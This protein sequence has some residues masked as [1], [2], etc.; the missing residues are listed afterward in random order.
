MTDGRAASSGG[1]GFGLSRVGS[2]TLT[3]GAL[4]QADVSSCGT[5]T[6]ADDDGGNGGDGW[7]PD[8]VTISCSLD[9]SQTTEGEGVRGQFTVQ[10]NN[11]ISVNVSVEVTANDET[12]TEESFIVPA[13]DS[14]SFEAIIGADLSPDTYTISADLAAIFRVTDNQ[15]GLSRV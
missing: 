11:S 13:N 14:L 9:S 4:P 1:S 5:I 15:F 10:N 12:L 7:D 3:A 2:P 8:R 6:I